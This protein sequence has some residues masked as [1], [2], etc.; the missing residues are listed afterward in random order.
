MNFTIQNYFNKHKEVF[1]KIDLSS[2]ERA[3]SMIK[4]CQK[5]GRK[6]FTCGNG[7]SA[8]NASHFVTDWNKMMHVKK[9][10]KIQT[11]S[12]CDNLGIMT[13]YSNDLS[14]EKIFSGQLF[15]LMNNGDILL[16]ISGSGNSKNLIEAIKVAKKKKCKTI[17]FVGFDGGKLKN[18]SDYVVH[19]PSFDMQICEDI[20]LMLGHMVMKSLINDKIY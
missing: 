11:I 3:I 1:S 20:H 17:S 12:L 4:K 10:K 9:N 14:F 2:I 7:G 15:T 19:V 8:Y 13:A 5:S 16:C 18:I 6:I